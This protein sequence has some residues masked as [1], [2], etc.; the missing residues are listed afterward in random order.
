MIP[1][2][3]VG[4]WMGIDHDRFKIRNPVPAKVKQ[5]MRETYRR[6]AEE[7]LSTGLGQPNGLFLGFP[8]GFVEGEFDTRQ[9]C[10]DRVL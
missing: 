8:Y 4:F 10:E 1:G 2:K 9:G 6:A 5:H 3:H 7:H